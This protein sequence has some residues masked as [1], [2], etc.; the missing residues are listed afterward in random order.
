M[1]KVMQLI[2]STL[3]VNIASLQDC[4]RCVEHECSVSLGPSIY[5]HPSI[6]FTETMRKETTNKAK[7]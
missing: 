6:I 7:R 3:K 5:A 2:L 1:S 4:K